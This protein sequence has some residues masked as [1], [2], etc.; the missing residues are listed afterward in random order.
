LHASLAPLDIVRWI[1]T[2][3]T[4]SGFIENTEEK[5]PDQE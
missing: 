3:K 4:V 1:F 5:E 2:G